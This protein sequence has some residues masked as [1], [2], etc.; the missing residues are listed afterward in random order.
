MTSVQDD[1]QDRVSIGV[2]VIVPEPSEEKL[3]EAREDIGELVQLPN[4]LSHPGN[5]P[6]TT[7]MRVYVHNVVECVTRC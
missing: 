5:F 7:C 2:D 1:G 6:F 3:S 4:K